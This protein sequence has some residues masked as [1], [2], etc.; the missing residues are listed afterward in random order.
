MYITDEDK[1]DIA[2]YRQLPILLIASYE[3]ARLEKT[4]RGGK[5]YNGP[6]LE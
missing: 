4:V 1:A 5:V 2:I 6:K 3:E